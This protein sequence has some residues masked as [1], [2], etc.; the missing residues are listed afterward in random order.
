MWLAKL[1]VDI[2]QAYNVVTSTISSTYHR[3]EADNTTLPQCSTK[4][5]T[6]LSSGMHQAVVD[7]C[8]YEAEITSSASHIH[9]Y[10]H[11]HIYI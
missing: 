3:C 11:T 9:S 10:F 2:V 4:L 8:G 6:F 1:A 7:I 5:E